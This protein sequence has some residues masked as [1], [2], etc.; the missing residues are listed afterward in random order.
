MRK[1]AIA[2]VAVV[3]ALALAAPASAQMKFMVGSGTGSLLVSPVVY[4]GT[5]QPGSQL[6]GDWVITIDDTG[7]PTTEPERF[8]YIW[9]TFFVPNY[10]TIPA[11]SEKWTGKFNAQTLP[12]APQ[13]WFEETGGGAYTLG[14]NITLNILVRDFEVDEYLSGYE[15]DH[16]HNF[17]STLNPSCDN[18]TGLYDNTYGTGSLS[19]GDQN[20]TTADAIEFVGQVMLSP[21]ESPVESTTWGSIK[22]LYE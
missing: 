14:G 12:T 10:T 21:C 5:F 7:W 20:F 11:G 3:L 13:F 15:K 4:S 18:S 17:N 19:G 16:D 9:N 6:T 1:L 22:A 2:A 8:N